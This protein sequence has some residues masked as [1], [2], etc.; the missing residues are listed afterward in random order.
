VRLSLLAAMRAAH[1][2]TTPYPQASAQCGTY[3]SGHQSRSRSVVAPPDRRTSDPKVTETRP[4]GEGPTATGPLQTPRSGGYSI[5]VTL[6]DNV[7]AD[8]S[9]NAVQQLVLY[10]GAETARGPLRR[11]RRRGPLTWYFVGG[12][13]RI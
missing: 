1:I 10:S 9:I 8:R 12:G 5:V 3:R 13:G 7:R 2:N 6:G 4:S 11:E